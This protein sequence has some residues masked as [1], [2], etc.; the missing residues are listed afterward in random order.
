MFKHQ[1]PEGICAGSAPISRANSTQ[2]ASAGRIPR[3]SSSRDNTHD[4]SDDDASS[5]GTITN[6]YSPKAMHYLVTKM[7]KYK[8]LTSFTTFT[9]TI[10]FI[11]IIEYF[12]F[13]IC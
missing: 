8:K 1:P 11:A 4:S 6:R 3:P 10:N 12:I 2:S 9:G 7:S 13:F 5:C